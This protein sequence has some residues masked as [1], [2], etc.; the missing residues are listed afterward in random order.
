ML[1]HG[2]LMRALP[3]VKTGSMT[4]PPRAQLSPVKRRLL[5]AALAQR[6]DIVHLS[7]IRAALAAA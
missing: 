2:I 4:K 1:P 3:V 6:Y 5:I 7:A